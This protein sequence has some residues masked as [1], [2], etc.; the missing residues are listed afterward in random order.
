M[1]ENN[2]TTHGNEPVEARIV[3]W[4]LGEA[5][6]FEAAELQR[7]CDQ[8][9][10]LRIFKRRMEV[11]H[12]L[13]KESEQVHK[14][15]RWKLPPTK[16]KAIEE[17][18]GKEL[19]RDREKRVRNSGQRAIWALAACLVMTLV[20]AGLV[21]P[22]F[23]ARSWKGGGEVPVMVSYEMAADTAFCA[24][25]TS[26]E[27]MVPFSRVATPMPNELIEGTPKPIHVPGLVDPSKSERMQKLE[28]ETRSSED[29]ES[30]ASRRNKQSNQKGKEQSR[31]R[32]E[33]KAEEEFKPSAKPKVIASQSPSSPVVLPAMPNDVPA[34]S[35][36]VGDSIDYDKG[37]G[38]GSTY[39]GR[40]D[41]ITAGNRSGDYSITNGTV[42][43]LLKS[44]ELQEGRDALAKDM[45]DEARDKSNA[46]EDAKSDYRRA[47]YDQ[48][49]AELLAETDSPWE[50]NVPG[51]QVEAERFASRRST[52][53]P[54]AP[55]EP[56]Q[57]G[58]APGKELNAPLVGDVPLVG[59]LFKDSK[60]EE[61]DGQAGDVR[62]RGLDRDLAFLGFNDGNGVTAYGYDSAEANATGWSVS[63]TVSGIKGGEKAP[64]QV[65]ITTKHV[66][67]LQ[68]NDKELGFDWLAGP[69][70]GATENELA[71]AEAQKALEQLKSDQLV[72]A[73]EIDLAVVTEES[74]KPLDIDSERP[75][76]SQDET[77]AADEPYSTFS[78]NI[79]D[80]S[81]RVAQ[82]AL[83]RGEQPD[84]TGIQ[85]EQFYNAVDYGDP[86][87]A[88]GQPVAGLVE[89]SAHPVIPGR[90]LLR[91][92]VKT[93]AAGRS[94]NQSLR[95]TLLVDLSGSM[96]REDRRQAMDQALKGLSQ[97]LTAN[98]VINVIGFSRTPS[99]LAD[100]LSGDQSAQLGGM[101]NMDANEGGTN[102]EEAIKL[103]EQLAKRHQQQGAQ[104]RMV[105]FTDGAANLGD[106]DPDSLAVKVKQLRQ[107]GIAFDI[108]GIAADDLNDG[109][110]AE[111]ARHGNGRYYVVGKGDKEADFAKQLAG[112][113]RPAAENVKVQVHFN[114]ARVASYKLI[115]FE[116]D[117]LNKE[118]FRNDAVDAAEMAAEEAGVAMYQVE[119]LADGEGEIGE[120]SVRFRDAA[121]GKMVERTWT[122]P[123]DPASPA[124]ERSSASMQLAALS[125]LA[126]QKLKG[127][128]LAEAIDFSKFA[129]VQAQVR[130]H[131]GPI[132]RVGEMLQMLDA[133]K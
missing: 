1:S 107:D 61:L 47:A 110:L 11:L 77:A 104:N 66:E 74:A 129:K 15:K 88:A 92:S 33:K 115:G 6:A 72:E 9:P 109:L 25:E 31:F 48:K 75:E 118:D 94:P 17:I 91:M 82:A 85:I 35:L 105:L 38:G 130:Q 39:A 123:Y 103:G 3:C 41:A 128:A 4:V 76:A 96:A 20:V 114:P 117:R 122:I 36:E 101:I 69:A 83:A 132:G 99:L 56:V 29:L 124:I 89:Q 2:F 81:F 23:T 126:G 93:A 8:Q 18:L 111:L 100:G 131:Y 50:A 62:Q 127:G 70:S 63:G 64:Q 108:A 59:G 119:P 27:N 125:M 30:L 42:D 116:K 28:S 13:L 34:P 7:L 71:S 79:S 52:V 51:A 68:A 40:A 102:L 37:W 97:L 57:A 121:T 43:R 10:E 98:D 112:A 133:L 21:S 54:F 87:P 78:L 24:P 113:F 60:N 90:N 19:E 32:G 14:D 84:P 46:P 55:A 16:R 120:M 86:A 65:K 53:D 58:A 80:A 73:T 45:L 106:A 67:A 22:L 95:L 44:R 12:G 49:R 26:K 5:S